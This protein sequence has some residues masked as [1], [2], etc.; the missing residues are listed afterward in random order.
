MNFEF[1]NYGENDFEESSPDQDYSA[2]YEKQRELEDLG[3]LRI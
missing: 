1:T 3:R 2:Y